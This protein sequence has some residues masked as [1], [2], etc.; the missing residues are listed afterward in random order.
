MSDIKDSYT[1][2]AL[3]T[4]DNSRLK[5]VIDQAVVMLEKLENKKVDDIEIDGDVKPL[6]K[7]L[8]ALNDLL[9]C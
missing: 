7:K 1:L 2:E 4:G 3:L 6:R 8:R 5:R 9:K